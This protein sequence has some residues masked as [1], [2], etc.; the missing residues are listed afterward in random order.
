MDIYKCPGV[1]FIRILRT[2]WPRIYIDSAKFECCLSTVKL[3]FVRWC[4]LGQVLIYAHRS[5]S[6]CQ[7][8]LLI[9]TSEVEMGCT[10]SKS[11]AL[12]PHSN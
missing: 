11:T 6:Q 2:N 10:G 5:L 9:S 7:H 1:L 12:K 8:V 3:C 4:S